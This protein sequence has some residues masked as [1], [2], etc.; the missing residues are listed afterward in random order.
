MKLLH[1]SDLHLGK[2][3]NGFSMLEEQ[4]YILKKIVDIAEEHS[5]DGVLIAG[6]IYDKT[7]PSSEAVGLLDD[8]LTTLSSKKIE[9]YLISG[10]HDSAE[11]LQFASRLL[12]KNRIYFATKFEGK[13]AKIAKKDEFGLVNFYLLPFIKPSVVNPFFEET[14]STYSEAVESILKTQFIE[15]SERNILVAHQFV[16]NMGTAQRSDS[17]TISLGGLDN[18]ECSLLDH[19][20]YVALGHLHSPQKV[21]QDCIRYAGSPLKYSF[22]EHRQKKGVT[23]IDL[24][25]K[26]NIIIQTIPLIPRK[27]MRVI[28]GPLHELIMV[29]EKE[30]TGKEDYIKAI[31]TDIEPLYDP[32]GKLRRIYPNIMA[33]EIEEQKKNR[34]E[35]WDEGIHQVENVSPLELFEEFYKRQNTDEMTQEQKAWITDFFANMEDDEFETD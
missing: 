15:K 16:T 25:E 27:D 14:I 9:I 12:E 20:D 24:Q 22:S 3:V 26:G 34:Q 11:R 2:R 17:E 7:V 33:I 6:D 30:I 23:L 28:K 29:G 35:K 5:V 10:N 1:I 13:L 8:F 19:F 18:I 32:L 31:L 4:Q 21:G